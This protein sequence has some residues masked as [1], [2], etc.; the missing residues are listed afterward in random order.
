MCRITK[1]SDGSNGRDYVPLS[2]FGYVIDQDA[3]NKLGR[4][5]DFEEKVGKS[6]DEYLDD[7][8]LY[9]NYKRLEEKLWLLERENRIL[10]EEGIAK[11]ELNER[12]SKAL[13]KA[14]KWLD[15]HAGACPYD[16]KL[17]TKDW[18]EKNCR[19]DGYTGHC[20]KAWF[21]KNE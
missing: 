10:D 5:E 9:Q 18:C 4:L 7:N 2:S 11:C 17:F 13:D 6:F 1:K 12:L 14:C 3:I 20:W 8:V 16:F 19:E 15:R 21:M